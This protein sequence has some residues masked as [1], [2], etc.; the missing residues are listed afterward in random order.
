M[1]LERRQLYEQA[2]HGT[3]KRYADL[4][5]SLL[6]YERFERMR[7]DTNLLLAHHMQ[8]AHCTRRQHEHILTLTHGFKNSCQRKTT[9][10]W[11]VQISTPDNI[12]HTD[13]TTGT[14]GPHYVGSPIATLTTT[15][16]SA[17]GSKRVGN[18]ANMTTPTSGKLWGPA[19]S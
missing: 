19:M 11:D 2:K 10:Y 4:K 17:L 3:V 6:T 15:T 13:T 14:M 16:K 12:P 8:Q 9:I 7:T 5:T 18:P 1:C